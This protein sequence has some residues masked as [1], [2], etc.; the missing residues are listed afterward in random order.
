MAPPEAWAD[1]RGGL[2]ST[3]QDGYALLA[4]EGHI[5]DALCGRWQRERIRD[6]VNQRCWSERQQAR[7]FHAATER[8]DAGLLLGIHFGF[9]GGERSISTLAAGLDG[10]GLM[11]EMH[12]PWD[13]AAL[14]NFH[15]GLSHLA[16]G[17]AA[18]ILE[19]PG[20]EA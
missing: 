19:E 9:D 17:Y 7:T 5:A 8:L 10:G 12:A 3:R 11:T 18:L 16:R 20:S 2:R 4:H 14:G 15:Q 1:G 6:W 13:D